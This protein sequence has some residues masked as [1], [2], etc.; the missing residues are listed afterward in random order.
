MIRLKEKHIEGGIIVL[1][2][3]F[4][5]ISSLNLPNNPVQIGGWVGFVT[6]ARFLPLVIGVMVTLLGIRMI[7]DKRGNTD[8]LNLLTIIVNMHKNLL[9]K[10]L[11]VVIGITLIYIILIGIIPFA[12]A[13]FIYF[14]LTIVYIN[15]GKLRLVKLFVI[16]AVFTVFI[17]Y[18]LPAVLKIPLP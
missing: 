12:I 13:T 4:I 7:I 16:S 15:F 8:Y 3:I 5:I 11:T 10:R 14:A 17:A 6:E 2:G 1:I 18:L 9:V